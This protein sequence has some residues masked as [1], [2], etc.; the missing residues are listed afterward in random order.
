[1]FGEARTAAKGLNLPT[2]GQSAFV[3]ITMPNSTG[4]GNRLLKNGTK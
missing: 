4:L 3:V 2:D 1:M